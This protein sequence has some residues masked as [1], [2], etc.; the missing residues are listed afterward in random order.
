MVIP[1]SPCF[2]M[3]GNNDYVLTSAVMG[4]KNIWMEVAEL[5]GIKSRFAAITGKDYVSVP[6]RRSG[7]ISF[8]HNKMTG[9]VVLIRFL[10]TKFPTLGQARSLIG[11]CKKV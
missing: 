9:P 11:D 4:E 7:L 10:L 1:V 3:M 5:F 8:E 2:Y 6:Q